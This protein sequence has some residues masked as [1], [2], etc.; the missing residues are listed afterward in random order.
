MDN[1]VIDAQPDGDK[2][3]DGEGIVLYAGE[4]FLFDG[5]LVDEPADKGNGNTERLD[6]FECH[7]RGYIPTKYELIHGNEMER[8]AF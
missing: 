3:D 7:G 1:K 8:T 6:K 4:G 2:E 5:H